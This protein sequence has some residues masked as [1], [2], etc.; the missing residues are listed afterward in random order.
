VAVVVATELQKGFYR[1]K[2]LPRAS[3]NLH[4]SPGSQPSADARAWAASSAT[5]VVAA[6]SVIISKMFLPINF[7][8]R[9]TWSENCSTSLHIYIYIY[10]EQESVCERERN[11]RIYV[12][13]EGWSRNLRATSGG[14][15]R[16]R[17]NAYYS[18]STL[19]YLCSHVEYGHVKTW[20]V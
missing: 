17:I 8:R 4:R 15:L 2:G 6:Y 11:I 9:E 16:S 7:V 12:Y 18:L 14:C 20:T 5:L 13:L 1:V 19:L 10:M 3:I